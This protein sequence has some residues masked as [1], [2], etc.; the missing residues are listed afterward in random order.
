M[1]IILCI[2]D[3]TCLYLQIRGVY[4]CVIRRKYNICP[5]PIYAQSG[6][7]PKFNT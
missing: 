1:V 4:G 6:I 3:T 2:H 5:T 7:T